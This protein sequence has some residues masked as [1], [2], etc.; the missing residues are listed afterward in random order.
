MYSSRTASRSKPFRTGTASMA[1]NILQEAFDGLEYVRDSGK[2]N[3]FEFATVQRF[4][5]EN[6]FHATVSGMEAN[7]EQYFKD[8]FTDFEVTER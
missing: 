2:T 4:A 8:V 5:Y 6:E 3:I 1:I 7:R